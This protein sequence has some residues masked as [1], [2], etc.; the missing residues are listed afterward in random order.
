M[1]ESFIRKITDLAPPTVLETEHGFQVSDKKLH[2]VPEL[3]AEPLDVSSLSAV[4]SYV[5]EDSKMDEINSDGPGLI[6]HIKSHQLVEVIS[7]LHTTYRSREIYLAATAFPTAFNFGR[8]MNVEEFI[9]G[10]Q[11]LFV[12]DDNTR[13]ILKV[14]GNLSVKAEHKTMDDGV[15]QSVT[16]KVGVARVEDVILPN[17]IELRPFRTFPEIEQPSSLFVLRIVK[18]DDGAKCGLFEADGGLWK[19]KAM[20]SINKELCS[21]LPDGTPLLA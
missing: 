14:V 16:A 4:V 15:S 21:S 1:D 3:C 6:V 20:G 18:G 13:D 9:V 7:P 12:Q 11:A 19:V 17:P 5:T 8:F 2:V 10:L